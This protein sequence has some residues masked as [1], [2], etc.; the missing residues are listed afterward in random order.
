MVA[1]TTCSADGDCCSG[2]CSQG[3]CSCGKFGSHCR[4]NSDCCA[5][6][7]CFIDGNGL[8][9]GCQLDAG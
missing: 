5:G 1:G 2:S 9:D 3:S 8:S 4:E 6:N 7:F